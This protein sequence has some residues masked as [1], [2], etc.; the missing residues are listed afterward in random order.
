MILVSQR[1]WI[2]TGMLPLQQLLNIWY[3]SLFLVSLFL[4]S[5]AFSFFASSSYNPP[6]LLLLS[7]FLSYFS[8]LTHCIGKYLEKVFHIFQPLLKT[9][10]QRYVY[11]SVDSPGDGVYRSIGIG[12]RV[13]EIIQ[14]FAE[15]C[16]KRKCSRRPLVLVAFSPIL[17]SKKLKVQA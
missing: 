15:Y 1:S 16:E 13:C 4:L 10:F 9:Y 7:L 14:R 12:A 3:C 17:R 2:Q 6:N 5:V 8:H 11:C